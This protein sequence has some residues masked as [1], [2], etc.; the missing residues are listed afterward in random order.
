[1]KLLPCYDD[2]MNIW[3]I[4]IGRKKETFIE[5]QIFSRFLNKL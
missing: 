3:R 4:P 5:V 1:M 2:F